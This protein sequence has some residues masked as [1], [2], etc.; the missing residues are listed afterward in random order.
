MI[1]IRIK[2]FTKLFEQILTTKWYAFNEITMAAKTTTQINIIKEV[3]QRDNV[4]NIC[5]ISNFK[6]LRDTYC[7]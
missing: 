5:K 7:F 4:Q 1:R 2:C 3:K 6:R